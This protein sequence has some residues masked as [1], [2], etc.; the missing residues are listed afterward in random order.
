MTACS[1]AD[2]TEEYYLKLS[3]A[4]ITFLSDGAQT[5]DVTIRA[6]PGKFK[7]ESQAGWIKIADQT[8]N[9]LTLGVEPNDGDERVSEVKITCGEM[10]RIIEVHQLGGSGRNARCR[11]E[12]SWKNGVL[13]PNGK[14]F[15]G[16]IADAGPGYSNI[17]SVVIRN[18]E[19]DEQ[20]EF[21]PY[22]DSLFALA[23]AGGISDNG[24]M[25]VPVNSGGFG[26][27]IFDVNEEDYIVPNDVP[28]CSGRP[29][30]YKTSSDGSVMVGYVSGAPSKVSYQPVKY[31]DGEAK[32]LPLPEHNFRYDE[33][34]AGIIARGVSADGSV[35]YGSTWENYDYG[36]AYWDK[37]DEFHWVGE[38]VHK[39]VETVTLHNGLDEPYQYNLTNGMTSVSYKY[40]ISPNGRWIA[41]TYRTE[42]LGDDKETILTTECPA[43]YNTETHTTYIF[44]EL[45]GCMT[46]GATDDGLGFVLDGV[47]YANS[48]RVVD[49]EKGTVVSDMK[50]WIKDNFGVISPGGYIECVTSD[51]K[52][53]LGRIGLAA[54][55]G[56]KYV[57]Y[58]IAP[59]LR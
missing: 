49:I 30:L 57:N 50:T 34:W 22:P 38:D 2:V 40:Q 10:E 45:A 41:G 9:S 35:V 58:Y 13:S 14:Y 28:E 32:L 1:Y 6:Y 43:F 7:A 8:D 55:Q 5:H 29:K 11:I 18:L 52:T 48:G 19:T 25:V 51:K 3:D 39:L 26:T 17:Y 42:S 37:N 24:M 16:V 23:D 31:V 53:L 59:P 44:E 33:L 47:T 15:G 4:E 46:S 20:V 21:G 54:A 27:V 56:M 12:K 36:M